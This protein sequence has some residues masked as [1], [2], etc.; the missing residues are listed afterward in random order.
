[1]GTRPPDGESF[2]VVKQGEGVLYDVSELSLALS[3]DAQEFLREATGENR[4][5]RSSSRLG[6]KPSPNRRAV[7]RDVRTNGWGRRRRARRLGQGRGLGD[8]VDIRGGIDDLERGAE[9]IP[10]QVVSAVRRVPMDR[11]RP[12]L[13]PDVGA[14]YAG[15]QYRGI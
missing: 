8:V 7:L 9:S 14:V 13:P 11:C 4:R 12:T 5:L 1:M 10:D 6:L 2:E 3:L 15:W